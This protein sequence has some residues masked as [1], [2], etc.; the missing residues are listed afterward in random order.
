MIRLGKKGMNTFGKFQT[1]QCFHQDSK[2]ARSQEKGERTGR[3]G[4]LPRGKGAVIPGEHHHQERHPHTTSCSHYCSFQLLL[5]AK[6]QRLPC[7]PC[8]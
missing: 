3:W 5:T 2:V 7:F 1:R 6:V 4:L 8:S